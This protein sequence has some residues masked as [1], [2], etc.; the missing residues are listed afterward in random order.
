[1][2]AILSGWFQKNTLIIAALLS[3]ALAALAVIFG[4]RQSGR[5][6]ERVEVLR[7]QVKEVEKAN[8]IR[9]EVND[10]ARAGTVPERVRKYYLPK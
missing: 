5:N 9:R 10:A 8:E 4:A 7:Y 1:M 2:L 3:A 6:A